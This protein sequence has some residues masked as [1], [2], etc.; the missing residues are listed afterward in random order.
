M[1][2]KKMQK[3]RAE[4]KAYRFKQDKGFGV[5]AQVAGAELDRIARARG[6]LS[7]HAV[8][9]E[10][11]PVDAALHPAFEWDDTSAGERYRVQQAATLI[12]AVVVVPAA[13]SGVNEHRAYVL[14]DMPTEKRPV[15]VDAQT[16]VDSPSLFASA[17]ARLEKKIQEATHSGRELQT[18]AE[19][20]GAEPER[21]ARIAL[22]MKALETAGAAVQALH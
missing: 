19:Q 22:A 14:T 21:L 20:A 5:S 6:H 3:L 12:R 18:L 9:E 10:A 2:N 1:S 8:V 15:Y 7:S 4:V 16:V 13:E 11:R 17:I